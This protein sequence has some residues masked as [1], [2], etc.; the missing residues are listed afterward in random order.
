MAI[1]APLAAVLANLV[2]PNNHININDHVTIPKPLS[3]ANLF[4]ECAT[5]PLSLMVSDSPLAA[6]DIMPILLFNRASLLP[7]NLVVI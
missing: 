1:T 4:V 2:S 5:T 3:K 7:D 6:V